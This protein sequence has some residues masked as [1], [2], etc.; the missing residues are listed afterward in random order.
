MPKN[1]N[2]WKKIA[3]S[4][5]RKW[6]FPNCAGAIDGKHVTLQAP[7]KSG[8]EFYNCKG[9]YRVVLFSVID[10]DYNFIYADVGCQCRISDGGLYRGT[11]FK[12]ALE[13][14]IAYFPP[15]CPLPGKTATTP[16]VFL[17]DDAFPL[18]PNV[19]K[20][21]SGSHTP[22]SKRKLFNSRLNRGRR[23][24]ENVFGVISTVFRVLRLPMSLEP[25]TAKK[26]TLSIIYLHNFLR[27]SPSKQI[28]NPPGIFDQECLHSG[29]LMLGVWRQDE[30]GGFS[31]F[32][33]VPR[34]STIYAESV[35]NRFTDYFSSPEGQINYISK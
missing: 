32:P 17:A 24:S 19:M 15:E 6:K 16:L 34:R 8:I 10:S 28:Y 21:Y 1:E 25:E 23:V 14:N 35:R 11:K 7:V 9:F 22:K 26:V 29:E 13:E 18:T 2:D 5:N 12:K 27:K 3:T 31:T 30:P 20:P 4:F 33:T